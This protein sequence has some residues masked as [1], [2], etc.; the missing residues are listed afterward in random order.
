[1]RRRSIQPPEDD[2]LDKPV[3]PESR[4]RVASVHG[5]ELTH[6]PI[7]PKMASLTDM[8]PP[9]TPGPRRAKTPTKQDSQELLIKKDSTPD[10]LLLDDDDIA[11]PSFLRK[12]TETEIKAPPFLQNKSKSGLAG[13]AADASSSADSKPADTESKQH[14]LSQVRSALKEKDVNAEPMPAPKPAQKSTPPAKAGPK[15]KKAASPVRD[16]RHF[17]YILRCSLTHKEKASE[18]QKQKE[19]TDLVSLKII[20]IVELKFLKS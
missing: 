3:A 2:A 18:I 4:R 6:K 15:G 1:M 16:V 9:T 14:I 7:E 12:K 20:F 19:V 13:K 11:T 17:I 5:D 8:N 10:P